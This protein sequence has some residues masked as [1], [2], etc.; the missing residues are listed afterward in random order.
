VLLIFY[1]SY[2][3]SKEQ[4]KKWLGKSMVEK[5][6][7][8]QIGIKSRTFKEDG[9]IRIDRLMNHICAPKLSELQEHSIIIW[10]KKSVDNKVKTWNKVECLT[11]DSNTIKSENS[12]QYS[13]EA[14]SIV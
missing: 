13:S 9:Y 10:T 5:K 4:V 6:K 12:C 3:E 2:R 7:Q 1:K 14:W 11:S 8:V